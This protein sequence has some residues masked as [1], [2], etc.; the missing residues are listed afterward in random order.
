MQKPIRL[1]DLKRAIR[2]CLTGGKGSTQERET[3][4]F[5]GSTATR[6]PLR[7]LVAEDQPVNQKVILKILQRLGYRP[8][9]VANGLEVL[10]ALRQ[11]FFDVILMDVQMPELGGL[12]ATARIRSTFPAFHQ[13]HIIALTANAM[14]EDMQAC[15]NAGMNDYVPKPVRVPDLIRALQGASQKA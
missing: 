1:L 6:H 11:Q 4:Q 5:D 8:E 14:S 3:R 13:P 15:L 7:I 10:Q 9:V 2:D 12:E